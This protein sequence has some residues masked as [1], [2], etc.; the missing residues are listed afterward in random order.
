MLVQRYWAPTVGFIEA[1]SAR[2]AAM[3]IEPI[4][5]MSVPQTSEVGPPF[6]RPAWN[7][8][9]T[10]SHVTCKLAV[11]ATAGRKRMY[12]SSLCR[13]GLDSISFEE[14]SSCSSCDAVTC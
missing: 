9:A 11:K 10:D 12:L 8:T 6:K 2:E 5:A 14:A 7:E 4:Q 13:I 1:I 3:A